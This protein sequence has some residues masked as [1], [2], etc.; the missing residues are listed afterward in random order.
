MTIDWHYI[1]IN[2]KVATS[3]PS[4][5]GAAS[6]NVCVT[7]IVPPLQISITLLKMTPTGVRKDGTVTPDL[8]FFHIDVTFKTT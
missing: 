8:T 7:T 4:I 3:N 6:L 2:Y 5:I 1:D